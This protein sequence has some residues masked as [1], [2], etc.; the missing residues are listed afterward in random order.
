MI[1]FGPLYLTFVTL[2][3]ACTTGYEH[4]FKTQK[5]KIFNHLIGVG[6][7]KQVNIG[8]FPAGKKSLCVLSTLCIKWRLSQ[9]E[10]NFCDAFFL[11]I[12]KV[13]SFFSTVKNMFNRQNIYMDIWMYVISGYDSSCFFCQ[14]VKAGCASALT[15]SQS[16]LKKAFCRT[17]HK[18]RL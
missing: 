4:I 7:K 8:N 1:H 12:A 16:L 6:H 18:P 11:S 3:C 9:C 13:T 10:K 14:F 5:C 2:T 15:A 17:R